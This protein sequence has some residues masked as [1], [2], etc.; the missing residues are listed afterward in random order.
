MNMVRLGQNFLVDTN[1]LD[2]IVR[3]AQL[4]PDDVVLEVGAGE[5]PL[6]E[7]LA[8]ATSHVHAIE[9]DRKLEP[10]LER[11][12]A[13]PN[14]DLHWGD[15]L[16]LDLA[17]LDPAPTR[18][19]SNLPYSIATPLIL[20]T[21]HELGGVQR[22]TVMVQREIGE[23]LGA[24]SG[25]REYGAPSVLVQLACE[26][27]VLRTVNPSVFR[28]PPR[29]GSMVIELTRVGPGADADTRD[30]VRTAFAHRRKTL[31]RSLSEARPGIRGRARLM[32]PELGLRV[33]VRP[34]EIRPAEYAELARGMPWRADGRLSGRRGISG[35][36]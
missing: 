16:K 1:L 9:L 18:V 32:L 30:L 33:E 3:D 17:G 8:A 11:V 27:K 10:A 35:T 21:I 29:V 26:T 6:T 19:V 31:T 7:R 28:P 5:G 22:W 12:A 34:E 23:R 13:L 20:R 36:L 25:R 15:A 14:V 2:A 24:E 4:E